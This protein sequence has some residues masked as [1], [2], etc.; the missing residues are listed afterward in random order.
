MRVKLLRTSANVRIVSSAYWVI[1]YL[2]CFLSPFMLRL[3]LIEVLSSIVTIYNIN[4]WGKWVPMANTSANSRQICENRLFI[5]LIGYAKRDDAI[6]SSALKSR[7]YF[8]K[9]FI[10][11]TCPKN[12]IDYC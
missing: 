10:R 9:L 12:T 3:V 6:S 11:G 8:N 7:Q 4:V 1:K 5:R 2:V